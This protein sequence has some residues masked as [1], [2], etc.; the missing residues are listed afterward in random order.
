MNLNL[1]K[2]YA[3]QE[4]HVHLFQ[5]TGNETFNNSIQPSQRKNVLLAPIAGQILMKN[6]FASID[7]HENY[8]E[9][10]L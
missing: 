10:S 2:S 5:I 4:C 7:L 9:A 3:H 8:I 6:L 1:H